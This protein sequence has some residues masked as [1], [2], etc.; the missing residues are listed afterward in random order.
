MRTF[1][2]TVDTEWSPPEAMADLQALFDA[3]GVPVTFFC[4]DDVPAITGKRHE[5]ALHPNIHSLDE[6]SAKIEA[7][8]RH[9]PSAR[10]IRTHT[11][12]MSSRLNAVFHAQGLSYQSNAYTGEPMQSAVDFGE[13]VK[14]L[15][16]FYMDHVN[17]TNPSINPAFTLDAFDLTRD[18]AYI[19]D[20]HPVISYVN[21]HSLA[22][23]SEAK[24]CYHDAVEL[25]SLRR[26]GQRGTRDLLVDLLAY[27]RDEKIPTLTC[28]DLL[29]RHAKDSSHEAASR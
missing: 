2:F 24:L 15:P 11:L 22:Q 3:A 13:G 18:G 16:I 7:L 8:K 23:Y 19:F 6:A 20:F 28:F 27:V 21:C 26:P 25:R 29:S 17:L 10:G 1:C 5:I 9:Y 4:T 12:F 14:S